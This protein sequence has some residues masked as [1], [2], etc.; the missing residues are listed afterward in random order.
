MVDIDDDCRLKLFRDCRRDR[1]PF[2]N[3][4]EV[5]RSAWDANPED[6][7]DY[8]K[9]KRSLGDAQKRWLERAKDAAGLKHN[10][11][12]P[13]CGP[14]MLNVLNDHKEAIERGLRGHQGKV[15]DKY[16]WSA[17][18]HNWYCDANCVPENKI[19]ASNGKPI[20]SLRVSRWP[21]KQEAY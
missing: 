11:I 17:G 7:D 16:L 10:S 9:W 6:Y 13:E 4:L 21:Q 8:D 1:T 2:I 20:T 12:D 15:L 14:P 18:Y 3:Y 19:S 5:A